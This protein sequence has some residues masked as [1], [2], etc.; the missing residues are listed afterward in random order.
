LHTV[1]RNLAL[2]ARLAA[3]RRRCLETRL[4]LHAMAA[5]SSRDDDEIRTVIDEEVGRLPEKYRAPVT[6]CYLAGK[7]NEEAARELGCPVGTVHG[8]LAWA[9]EALRARLTRRGFALPAGGL[10]VLV[11]AET[12]PARLFSEVVRVAVGREV[13]RPVVQALVQEYAGTVVLAR[14]TVIVAGLLLFLTGAGVGGYL[15]APPRS[16]P[17]EKTGETPAEAAHGAGPVAAHE[18]VSVQA[19]PKETWSNSTLDDKEEVK[20][21]AEERIKSCRAQFAVLKRPLLTPFM[22]QSVGNTL[23]YRTFKTV[24][25]VDLSKHGEFKWWN[26]PDGG[27]RTLLHDPNRA[28]LFK[29]WADSF[30]RNGPPGALLQNSVATAFAT[31]GTRVMVV[32]DLALP[33][34]PSSPAN[35]FVNSFGV[36]GEAVK[37]NTLKGFHITSGKL[38]WELGGKFDNS[39]FKSTVFLGAP[40]CLGGRFYVLNEKAG[41]LRLACLL[42]KDN[43]DQKSPVPPEFLWACS[44]GKAEPDALD[45][46]RRTRAAT[47]AVSEDSIIC[48]TN[49]GVVVSVALDGTLRWTFPYRDKKEAPPAPGKGWNAAAPI[50]QDG[51][52]VCTAPDGEDLY[53]IDL[54]KGT[55]LWKAERQAGLYLAGVAGDVVLIVGMEGVRT[56]QLS[57][58]KP[59]WELK[60]GQ[61]TGGRRQLAGAVLPLAGD[62]GRRQEGAGGTG[63]AAGVGWPGAWTVSVAGT[64]REFARG[65]HHPDFTVSDKHQM[66]SPGGPGISRQGRTAVGGRFSRRLE[67]PQ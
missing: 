42:P 2:N 46:N 17:S 18:K 40:I 32:D 41:E 50:I 55:L 8:R 28:A 53:C 21:W 15:A 24:A 38:V 34:P 57:N 43:A 23:I 35:K 60:V 14:G 66:L 31:D 39:D 64:V 30:D 9:R 58:G 62:G 4:G 48:V 3:K 5:D 52:V 26:D 19:A 37:R 36:L 67:Q 20:A 10:A 49:A 16:A 6:L 54:K 1:A 13:I 63:R 33:P 47:L 44:L 65:R 11:A 45:Y 25:A 61:P 51:K 56:L 12:A 27:I 59:A 22:P 7:T 29:S